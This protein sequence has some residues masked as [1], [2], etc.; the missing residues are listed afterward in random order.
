VSK[1]ERFGVFGLVDDANGH[2]RILHGV[3]RRLER[4]ELG[5]GSV[6]IDTGYCGGDDVA[7]YVAGS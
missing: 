3:E 6:G 2:A 1:R 5:S 7:R 4:G